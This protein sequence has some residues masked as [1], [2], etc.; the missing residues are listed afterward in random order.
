MEGMRHIDEFEKLKDTFPSAES[1]IRLRASSKDL[2]KDLTSIEQEI[3]LLLEFYP[4]LGD[5]VDNC[6]F[7]DYEVYLTINRLL[8]E[9]II[10]IYK[11]EERHRKLTKQPLLLPDQIFKLRELITYGQKSI[12]DIER[13]RILVVAPRNSTI[14]SFVNICKDVYGFTLNKDFLHNINHERVPIGHFGS[15]VLSETVEIIFYV[16]PHD[17][18]YRP[19]WNIFMR[20]ALGIIMLFDG[21]GTRITESLKDANLY[22]Y[23]KHGKT[24]AFIVFS[25]KKSTPQLVSKIVSEFKISREDSLFVISPG[26]TRGGY[27]PIQKILENSIK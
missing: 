22:F 18:V 14:K 26:D 25:S 21:G 9:G 10:E 12:F 27:L 11:K 3:L 15:L 16:V 23:D 17:E 8:Q 24:V 5:I 2:P 1:F 7:P 4:R 19:V 13:G 20:N 6:T